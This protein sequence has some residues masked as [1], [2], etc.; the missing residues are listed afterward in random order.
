MT[1]P[2]SGFM[3][4]AGAPPAKFNTCGDT[5]GGRILEKPV[6][7]Q[8]RDFKTGELLTWKDGNPRMQWIVTVQTDLR[9]PQIPDDDGKRRLFLKGDS[10]KAA[11][12]AVIS[13]GD[14]DLRVG[15]ELHL[16]YIND[17]PPARPGLDP[18]K[19]YT[20][21]Y[22]KPASGFTAQQAPQQGTTLL[23][24]VPAQPDATPPGLPPGIT[25]EAWAALQQ[26]GMA[27]TNP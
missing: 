26:L 7:Q 20:A 9:N 8:Q 2:N 25:P 3:G 4:S 17:E 10:L 12:Q 19:L 15:A 18:K 5:V 21:S 27:P 13:A 6:E 11:R 22:T 16:T 24:G 23:P 1:Q 14:N